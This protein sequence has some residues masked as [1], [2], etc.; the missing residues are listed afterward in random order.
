MTMSRTGTRALVIVMMTAGCGGHAVKNAPPPAP[1]KPVVVEQELQDSRVFAASFD[2]VWNAVVST[3]SE[4]RYQ[5]ETMERENGSAVTKPVNVE[6]KS[7]RNALNRISKLPAI[8]EGA[9]SKGWH[10]LSI[11]VTP[12]GGSR[13]NVKI[14]THIEGFESKVSND[15]HVC[16]SNGFLEK[17]F[18]DSVGSKLT[19]R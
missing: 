11:F 10:S 3:L 1:P 4:L 5:V 15:W 2:K 8:P 6:G 9:W 16:Y 7:A 17:Q 13:T 14:T 19:G 18:L 12:G